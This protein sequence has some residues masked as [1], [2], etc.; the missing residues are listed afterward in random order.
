MYRATWR[1]AT[2]RQH[3]STPAPIALDGK[4]GGGGV[5]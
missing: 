1:E 4:Q 3:E 2:F 5:E